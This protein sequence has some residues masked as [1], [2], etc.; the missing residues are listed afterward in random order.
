MDVAA[1][2]TRHQRAVN[3]VRWSPSGELLASGDDESVIFIWKQKE[4]T[5]PIN[6]CDSTNDSDKE[7]WITLKVLR[8][9][10]EDVY[11]LSWSPNSL[12]L[13]SG[14][15]D[16]TAMVWDV[17]KGKSLSILS[18]HKG[19]VQGVAW[20]PLNQYLATLSTDRYFRVFDINT[21][22]VISRNSKCLLPVPESSPLHGKTVRLFHDDTLQ[23]FFRRLA[24]SPDGQL[25]ITPSGVAEI[26]GAPKPLNTTYIY[27]RFS[28]KQPAVILPSPDQYTVAVRCCP[29]LFE[30]REHDE[31][32]VSVIPL[33]YRMVFA[34]ATKSSVYLYDTQQKTPFGLI[35]NIHYTRLTD[36]TWSSD[37]QILVVSST[38]GFCSLILFSK[39]ELGIVYKKNDE[40]KENVEEKIVVEEKSIVV[41]KKIDLTPKPI[42]FRR[43]SKPVKIETPKDKTPEKEL[44]IISTGVK[45]PSPDMNKPV[46]PIAIRRFPR[47]QA[48]PIT[49][50]PQNVDHF[51]S[52]STNKKDEEIVV[53]PPKTEIATKKS[54]KKATPI[55]VRRQPRQIN[56]VEKTAI[57]EEAMDA[58]PVPLETILKKVDEKIIEPMVV[59]GNEYDIRLVLEES[60]DDGEKDDFRLVLEESQDDEIITKLEEVP[61][62]K[63]GTP[64][65]P[66]RVELKTI[67]TPKSKKKL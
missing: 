14:S 26:E 54:G 19:F 34:V 8:G 52:I 36:L 10:M 29:L 48:S 49:I 65:T 39:D 4:E 25:I 46:T 55:A 23:T 7:I 31:N 60:Q 18:D 63:F 28:L 27:S 2:L 15:V 21:K 11:D 43:K 20:D 24:F 58:W 50:K 12:N 56:P 62:Q 67:S 44:S 9:H 38:D 13:I 3:V 51:A 59:D 53:T 1:D 22:K 47:S 42:E 45:F 37:G 57:V 41:E 61:V 16:N 35:S 6:I 40:D 32:N 33:P 5:E 64:K 30:L 17:L 66:R